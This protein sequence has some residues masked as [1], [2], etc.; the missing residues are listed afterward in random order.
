M[1]STSKRETCKQEDE[2]ALTSLF[3]MLRSTGELARIIISTLGITFRST[4]V[5]CIFS[6][7]GMYVASV[8]SIQ[9][10][11]YLSPVAILTVCVIICYQVYKVFFADSRSLDGISRYRSVNF[12]FFVIFFVVVFNLSER[13][14]AI[15]CI[16][17]IIVHLRLR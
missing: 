4:V 3:I 11:W 2:K 14:F 5:K 8:F 1:S 7:Q 10:C 15:L 9:M 12:L 6:R 13:L 16:I 17:G